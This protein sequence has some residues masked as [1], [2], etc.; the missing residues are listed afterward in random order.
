MEANV[1]PERM[2]F[3]QAVDFAC[4]GGKAAF[5]A[6]PVF[7]EDQERAEGVRVVVILGD[8]RGGRTIRFI[9]GPFFSAG[10][11]ANEI[12]SDDEISDGMRDMLFMPSTF[13][14]DWL[15]DQIQV[16]VARLVQAAAIVAPDMPDY[17]AAKA[18]AAAPEVMFPIR[19]IGRAPPRSSD[20][21]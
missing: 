3:E 5:A 16:L 13:S 21:S 10:L 20:K 11:A 19:S 17:L 1:Q 15:S 7:G 12:L 14:E 6:A 2:T 9:A 8:G 4:A 18:R